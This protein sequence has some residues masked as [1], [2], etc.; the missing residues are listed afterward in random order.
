MIKKI[1]A[2][3]NELLLAPD[4][5]EKFKG[6]GADVYVTSPAEFAALLKSD[7]AKWSQVIKDS[8]AKID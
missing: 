2:D 6:Q 8:G 1:N 7:I 5:A 3:I 4:V